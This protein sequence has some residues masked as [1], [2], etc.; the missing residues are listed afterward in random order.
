M[1][2]HTNKRLATKQVGKQANEYIRKYTDTQ[3]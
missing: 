2:K 1:N 3:I